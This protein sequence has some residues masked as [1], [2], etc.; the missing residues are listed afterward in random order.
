[1]SLPERAPAWGHDQARPR[2][3]RADRR[4]EARGEN[5]GAHHHARAAAGWRV[6]DSAVAPKPVVAN[7]ARLKR[8]QAPRQRFA[9][10]RL[11]KR[12]GE[13]GGKEG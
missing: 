6:V 1:L 13:H 3:V 7:V 9:S 5:V 4:I 11:A 12:A 2:I 8:P 10:E